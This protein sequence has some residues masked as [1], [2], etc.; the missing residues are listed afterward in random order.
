MRT[1]KGLLDAE[2]KMAKEEK[3]RGKLRE[4][5]HLKDGDKLCGRGGWRRCGG[6]G[7]GEG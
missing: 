5:M 2:S 6:Q 1:Q 4:Y 3:A 7:S